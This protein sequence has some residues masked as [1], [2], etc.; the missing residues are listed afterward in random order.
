MKIEIDLTPDEFK[1][2]FVPSDKQVE[3]ATKLTAAYTDALTKVASE[4]ANSMYGGIS[5]TFNKNKDTHE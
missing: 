5:K 4:M 3:F 1:E 2:L